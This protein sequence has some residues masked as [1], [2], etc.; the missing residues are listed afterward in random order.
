MNIV[1]MVGKQAGLVGML[2]VLAK[3]HTIKT[4]VCYDDITTNFC[5][6]YSI[7]VLKS[8]KQLPEFDYATTDSDMLLC[9]HGREIIPSKYFEMIQCINVHP[10]L[11]DYPGKEPIKRLLDSGNTKASVGV[12]WMSEEVDHGKSIIEIPV[13]V[14]GC[15]TESEVYNKLYPTYVKVIHYAFNKLKR[16]SN[17]NNRMD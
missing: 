1:M 12:N 16:E 4:A 14:E 6:D 8:I 15:K 17:E 11:S 9:V 3:G 7:P 10:C 13:D 5:N 2:T